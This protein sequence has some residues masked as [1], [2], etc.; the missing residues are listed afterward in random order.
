VK[1]TQPGFELH[2]AGRA[3]EQAHVIAC[4]IEGLMHVSPQDAT[5]LRVSVGNGKQRVGVVDMSA[6]S[7]VLPIGT[8]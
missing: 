7:Q 6:S 5:H 3:G 1:S 8:G 4:G 2:A